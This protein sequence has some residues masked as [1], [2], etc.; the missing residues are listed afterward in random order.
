MFNP[1]RSACSSRAHSPKRSLPSD[2]TAFN[3]SNLTVR[4]S[5]T[6]SSSPHRS[7]SPLSSRSSQLLKNFSL[8]LCIVFKVRAVIF[9]TSRQLSD[10]LGECL[11]LTACTVYQTPLLLSTP[12][13]RLYKLIT[14]IHFF[15][16]HYPRNTEH[17]LPRF[18]FIFGYSRL[19]HCFDHRRS[20]A[21]PAAPPVRPR[22][23]PEVL[24]SPRR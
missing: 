8:Y 20:P 2:L 9:T 14:S 21:V 4:G 23:F 10:P 1:L 18:Y 13:L 5:L 3:S 24:Q 12:F 22:R 19:E 16:S 7:R 17:C 15:V 6:R 11:S